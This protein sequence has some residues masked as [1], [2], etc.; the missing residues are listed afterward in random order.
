MPTWNRSARVSGGD[1]RLPVP[2]A[3]LT[4]EELLVIQQREAVRKAYGEEGVQLFDKMVEAH[5]AGESVTIDL[6]QGV[7]L[8]EHGRVSY[9]VAQ[10]LTY[11]AFLDR[12]VQRTRNNLPYCT[13]IEQA[14]RV[15]IQEARSSLGAVEFAA[16]IDFY[17]GHAALLLQIAARLR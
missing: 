16:A 5:A 9:T 17:G 13:G 4:R 6:D 12:V 15:A 14:A 3:R 2:L 8:D 1:K 10:S 11:Q 7:L